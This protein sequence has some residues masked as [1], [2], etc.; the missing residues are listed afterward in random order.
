MLEP[1]AWGLPVV[2]G[3]SDFNF[4]EVSRLLQESG[5]LVKVKDASALT[6][7][8]ARWL[9]SAGARSSAG[10]AARK[11]VEQNKGALGRLVE[12][13]AKRIAA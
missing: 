1:A 13:I 10:D 11:V 7:Q 2:T 12:L 6:N 4:A 8:L 9:R 5:G 3:E